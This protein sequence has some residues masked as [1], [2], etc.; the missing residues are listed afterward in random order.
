MR[1]CCLASSPEVCCL[2]CLHLC[3][4]HRSLGCADWAMNID[5]ASFTVS[6]SVKMRKAD[7]DAAEEE[8]PCTSTALGPQASDPPTEPLKAYK[9]Q[10]LRTVGLINLAA[11][12]ERCDEQVWIAFSG[13]S[14]NSKRV[15]RNCIHCA[16]P[17]VMIHSSVQ[18]LPALYNALGQAFNA[19]P[20]QLGYLTLAR[21]LVQALASPLGGISGTW[22]CRRLV[23]RIIQALHA[24]V[25]KA[26]VYAAPAFV[27]GMHA[28]LTC[29]CCGRPLL[30][31]GMGDC[32]GLR[33]V[34]RDDDRLR[35][36]QFRGA[37]H[38]LLGRERHRWAP[39]S[40]AHALMGLRWPHI[41][42]MSH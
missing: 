15:P 2:V 18:I 9:A 6:R 36:V 41:R 12:M 27:P 21:A 33:A 24:C 39:E 42:L 23:D 32:A 38:L 26:P 16:T 31:Q 35:L 13:P 22:Q 37:G 34:G 10:R 11:V 40:I 25:V 7:S 29:A 8:R 1:V 14:C 28:G 20:T 30:Q 5:N 3:C 19:S 4:T 17:A